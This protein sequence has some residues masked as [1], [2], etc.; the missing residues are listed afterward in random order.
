M[1]FT[2]LLITT[3]KICWQISEEHWTPA[4]ASYHHIKIFQFF[5][6]LKPLT[7]TRGNHHPS[8]PASSDRAV[9]WF[10]PAL[11]ETTFLLWE[12]YKYRSFRNVHRD[13][14]HL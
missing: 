11:Y 8:I 7:Y 4:Y 3:Y 1:L 14:K 13:Y 9:L 12:V 5:T 10:L 6:D 2:S